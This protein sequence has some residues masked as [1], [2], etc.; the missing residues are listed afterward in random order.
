MRPPWESGSCAFPWSGAPA[1]LAGQ[2]TL[3]SCQLSAPS[4]WL[5]LSWD[6]RDLF[7]SNVRF[8]ILNENWSLTSSAHEKQRESLAWHEKSVVI[9]SSRATRGP[10]P[11]LFLL[12]RWPWLT[13][14]RLMTLCTVVQ[15][16]YASSR[17]CSLNF[18]F[19]TYPTLE[20]SHMITRVN[21]QTTLSLLG[22]SN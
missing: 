14:V 11:R 19:S 18:E 9:C 16:H 1:G 10:H 17:N 7:Y 15:K 3:V 5:P 20:I 2:M 6:H 21:H 8:P 4:V 22:P 13:V 12:C